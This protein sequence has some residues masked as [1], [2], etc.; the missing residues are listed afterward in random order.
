MAGNGSAA[1]PGLTISLTNLPQP[2]PLEQAWQTVS[3]TGLW[4]IA[5]PS[6][7]GAVLA[8]VLLY[9][10]LKPAPQTAGESGRES[11]ATVPHPASQRE[12]LVRQIA[13]L[14]RRF[15]A[16]EL[17]EAIYRSERTRLRDQALPPSANH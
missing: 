16:G 15:E 11:G 2:G 14:D 1:C 8:A 5:I 3:S 9:G 17:E 6:V 13:L 7:L 4:A 12:Q 10:G